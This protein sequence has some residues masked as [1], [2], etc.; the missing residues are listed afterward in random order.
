M[1]YEVLE[2]R[3][4]WHN[5]QNRNKGRKIELTNERRSRKKE[6]TN[7]RNKKKYTERNRTILN[8][9]RKQDN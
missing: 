2:V 3:S 6:E 5:I 1:T 7:K 4:V 8:E 9:K